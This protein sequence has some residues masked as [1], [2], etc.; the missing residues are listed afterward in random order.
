MFDPNH[1][2]KIGK[3][4]KPRIDHF[5]S[6]SFMSLPCVIEINDELRIYYGSRDIKNRSRIGYVAYDLDKSKELYRT[7]H[8]VI[9]LGELGTFDDNGMMPCSLIKEG[10]QILMYYVG[11]NPKSTVRFSFYSGL[12]ISEDGGNN[13]KRYSKAPILERTN[14]EPFVNAS[15]MVIKNNNQFIMYYVSGE[16]WINPELPKYNIKIAISKNGLDWERTGL[17]AIDFADN[18]EH[19]LARPSVLIN[20]NKYYMWFSHKGSDYD[21]GENYRL[22]FAHS[23]D[24]FNW[25]RED[26]KVKLDLG[27]NDFDN[28]MICYQYVFKY[29]NNYYSLYNGNDFGK[30]G[31]GLAKL[32]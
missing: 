31:I 8:P 26:K 6:Q 11:W 14:D 27:E 32:I 22:G 16:G 18:G 23:E 28:K 9:E 12:A 5:W 3:I 30:D 29:K 1:W 4:L 20:E 17:T 15:P 19:A 21:L 10:D 25:K 7:S 24:G 2:K 13:F